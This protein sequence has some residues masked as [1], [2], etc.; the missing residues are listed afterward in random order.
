[1][2]DWFV[3]RMAEMLWE[4]VNRT[5]FFNQLI[6]IST[7]ASSKAVHPKLNHYQSKHFFTCEL[8]IP[9][10]SLVR[11]NCHHFNLYDDIC[12]HYYD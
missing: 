3:K 10:L 11:T 12:V 4:L 1:M 6:I 8:A 2:I 7:A 5:P 9:P